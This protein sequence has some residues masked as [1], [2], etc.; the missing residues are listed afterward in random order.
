M[1]KLKFEIDP[2]ITG[3]DDPFHM[4]LLRTNANRTVQLAK[5]YGRNAFA[6]DGKQY[7]LGIAAALKMA[8]EDSENEKNIDLKSFFPNMSHVTGEFL[9]KRHDQ[10]EFGIILGYT[11]PT[12]SSRYAGGKISSTTMSYIYQ[13]Q[14]ANTLTL[15]S[16]FRNFHGGQEAMNGDIVQVPLFGEKDITQTINT[17]QLLDD[18][19]F[20]LLN[21][22]FRTN[23]SLLAAELVI[24]Y[25]ERPTSEEKKQDVVAIPPLLKDQMILYIEHHPH[26]AM[27][28]KDKSKE[29]VIAQVEAYASRVNLINLVEKLSELTSNQNKRNAFVD[30]LF[31]ANLK[32]S[33][34]DINKTRELFMQVCQ[35]ALSKSSPLA[36]KIGVMLNAIG[37]M[38]SQYKA[39]NSP[40]TSESLTGT[41]LITLL[42]DPSYAVFAHWISSNP[43]PINGDDINLFITG[44]KVNWQKEIADLRARPITQIEEQVYESI[45]T[46]I[47]DLTITLPQIKG[48]MFAPKIP[49]GI[50]SMQRII[51]KTDISD[52]EKLY[53]I[54]D[55]VTHEISQ[56][57]SG[58]E[59]FKE[60][61]QAIN[62]AFKGASQSPVSVKTAISSSPE[63]VRSQTTEL[64]KS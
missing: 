56:N 46:K 21:R 20:K 17:Y 64:K 50:S 26:F 1:P 35:I 4:T 45:K 37:K 42:N 55:V 60:L 9:A 57:S 27:E 10:S 49:P 47:A 2:A 32:E 63:E 53:Q 59:T 16:E 24:G 14:N 61:Q 39:E 28:L 6:I 7:D 38:D 23:S 15:T 34:S 44:E 3:F 22:E 33:F 25:L 8:V 11:T 43:N 5:D 48:D 40:S 29:M 52:K 62:I 31:Q 58:K 41:E 51:A 19:N 12:Y 13:A 36:F 18:G 54:Y 30:I